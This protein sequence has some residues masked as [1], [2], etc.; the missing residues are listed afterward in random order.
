MNQLSITILGKSNDQFQNSICIDKVWQSLECSS[1]FSFQ[2]LPEGTAVIRLSFV[3]DSLENIFDGEESVS[4]TEQKKARLLFVQEIKCLSDE[5]KR[6]S[7][8][9]TLTESES[10]TQT[11]ELLTRTKTLITVLQTDHI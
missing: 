1:P 10:M 6:E 4:S 8:V 2:F 11:E 5:A 9:A 3:I 7:L